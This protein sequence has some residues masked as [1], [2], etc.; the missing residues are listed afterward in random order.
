MVAERSTKNTSPE[1]MAAPRPGAARQPSLAEEIDEIER[2]ELVTTALQA[3]ES[4]GMTQH[5][6]EGPEP[7]EPE[8]KGVSQTPKR[9]PKVGKTPSPIRIDKDGRT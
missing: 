6:P 7:L 4:H 9:T 5:R 1:A 3:V 2:A 8:N